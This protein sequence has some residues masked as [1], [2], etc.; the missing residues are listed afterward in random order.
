MDTRLDFDLMDEAQRA[1]VRGDQQWLA[2]HP[3]WAAY[4]EIA[5]V[6]MLASHVAAV[7]MAAMAGSAVSPVAPAAGLGP[8]AAGAGLAGAP[9]GERR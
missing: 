7:Q 6:V 5:E 1:W 2:E 9:E 8:C 3:A 4:L